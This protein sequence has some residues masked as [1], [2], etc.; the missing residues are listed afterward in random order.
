MDT[1]ICIIGV[2]AIVVTVIVITTTTKHLCKKYI[3]HNK[4][5][6]TSKNHAR[7]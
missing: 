7:K 2:V 3:G 6:Q 5:I 4:N 1:V